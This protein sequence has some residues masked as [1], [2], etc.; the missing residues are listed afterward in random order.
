MMAMTSLTDQKILPMPKAAVPLSESSERAAISCLL[1]NFACLDAMSWPEDLF[2]YE[3]H[4][5]ILRAIRELHE[6]GAATDFFAVQSLLDRQGTLDEVGGAHALIDLQTVMPTGD[7]GIAGWHRAALMDARRYRMALYALRKAEEGFL[8]QEGDIASVAEAL[9]AAAALQETP[10][11]GLKDII[12]DLTIEMERREPTET[13]PSGIGSVDR[14]VSFKRGELLTVAAP[15]SGGKS[16]MLLQMALNALRAGKRVAV[17][18]LE[19]PATQVVGRLLSAMCGFNIAAL[20]YVSREDATNEHLRKFNAAAAELARYSLEVESNLTD[21]EAIDGAARELVAKE[22]ADLIIV[23]YIQLIHLRALGS[24]ETRE[25]HVSEITKRLKSLALHLN[26]AVATASQLNDDTP[27]KLR[28]S[29]AIGHHSDH[30]WFLSSGE[31]GGFL[32]VMKN[33]DGERGAAIPVL[34]HGAT[35]QFVPRDDRETP[36][37]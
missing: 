5:I 33:R 25:Q 10:R 23:D 29:R 24:N 6:A 9:S 4:K 7:P 16:I 14:V 1:Q 37:K 12:S 32:S 36:T 11:K 27:P 21:W 26:V 31:A 19:M 17:F 20:K 18:S 3:K 35:S 13:F 15:T 22:K 8:R 34:M 30:V 2:F 28:E